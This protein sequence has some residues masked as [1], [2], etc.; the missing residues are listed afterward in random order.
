LIVRTFSER[1][2][3]AESFD[4]CLQSLLVTQTIFPALKPT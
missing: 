1:H 3:V 4:H 2:V